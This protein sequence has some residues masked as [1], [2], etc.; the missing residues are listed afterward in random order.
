MYRKVMMKMMILLFVLKMVM[1]TLM[2]TEMQKT[3]PFAFL[4]VANADD[5]ADDGDAVCIPVCINM[6]PSV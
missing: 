1:S 5:I 4:L 6:S 3:R 2:M